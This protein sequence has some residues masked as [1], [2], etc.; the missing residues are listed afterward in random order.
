MLSKKLFDLVSQHPATQ[1]FLKDAENVES[2][3]KH[4]TP[5]EVVRL[6]KEYPKFF[7]WLPSIQKNDEKTNNLYSITLVKRDFSPYNYSK[8]KKLKLYVDEGSNK[9]LKILSN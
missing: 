3:V 5:E 8:L 4:V 6:K 1:D 2:L 7:I 9:I